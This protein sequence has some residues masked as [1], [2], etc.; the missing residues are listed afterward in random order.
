MMLRALLALAVAGVPAI[1]AAQPAATPVA[2]PD[3][4][5]Q[6]A[7][8]R[9]LKQMGVEA[10]LDRTFIQLAPIF[11]KAVI[12]EMASNPASKGIIDT[13]NSRAPENHDRMIAILSQ[14]FMVAIKRQYPAYMAR[15]ATEY[16]AAFT[17]DELNAIAAFYASGAGAKALRL[18]PEIQA[19]MGAAGRE[20]GGVAGADAGKHAFE[21][22]RQEM[23][24]EDRNKNS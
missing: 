11:A 12:G 19:R 2:A 13:L 6:A 18:M 8:E 16:A 5:R 1:A 15:A 10:T 9:L 21:R 3:P 17:T 7:A 22:I 14:E 24:P 4:A 23:L 20:L